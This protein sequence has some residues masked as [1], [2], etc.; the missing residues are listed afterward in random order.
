MLIEIVIE[1]VSPGLRRSYDKEVRES[2]PCFK[3]AKRFLGSNYSPIQATNS[4][5]VKNASL[6]ENGDGV[7][8]SREE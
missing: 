6:L 3:S 1:F 5:A 2:H 4:D 7:S 8:G